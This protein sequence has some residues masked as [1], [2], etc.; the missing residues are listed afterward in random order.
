[1]LRQRRAAS[2][3]LLRTRH[4]ARGFTSKLVESKYLRKTAKSAHAWPTP[5]GS[6]GADASVPTSAARK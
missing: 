6:G 4:S 2:T 3:S 1:M 5:E